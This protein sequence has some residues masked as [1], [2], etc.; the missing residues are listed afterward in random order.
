MSVQVVGVCTATSRAIAVPVET[1]MG[2]SL[3]VWS[4]HFN[5]K[6]FGPLAAQMKMVKS[7]DQLLSVELLSG[8]SL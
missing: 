7:M 3:L 8:M 1:K 4:V 5:Y 6:M 2:R